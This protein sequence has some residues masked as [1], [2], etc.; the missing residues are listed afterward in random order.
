MVNHSSS[1][2]GA[3]LPLSRHVVRQSSTRHTGSSAPTL[4]TPAIDA[5]SPK[6]ARGSIVE[7]LSPPSPLRLTG[8]PVTHKLKRVASTG[9]LEIVHQQTDSKAPYRRSASES[10]L[11]RSRYLPLPDDSLNPDVHVLLNPPPL[12]LT[13]PGEYKP[14]HPSTA[15]NPSAFPTLSPS[16]ASLSSQSTPSTSGSS[17]LR[18]LF[19]K[20]RS[21]T[22]Q[23]T[24][25]V[26]LSI[27]LP[28]CRNWKP[29]NSV[30]LRSMEMAASDSESLLRP[31]TDGTVFAG[32][33]EG[34][35]SRAIADIVDPSRNDHFTATFLSIYQ[36]FAT[37]ERL[38]DIL[39]RRY[40]PSDLGP[41]FLRPRYP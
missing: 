24:R 21:Q 7:I 27:H 13:G 19:G 23:P 25:S 22:T 12:Q 4:F 9:F 8:I 16:I 36:L 32:N 39:K 6:E 2:T 33:L 41:A 38:F 28:E 18:R 10:P 3:C 35:V 5:S 30:V 37:S 15:P 14:L 40:E 26:T 34:L 29:V 20:K 17:R 11:S 1:H 31:A